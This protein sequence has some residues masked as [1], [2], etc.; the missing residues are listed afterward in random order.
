MRSTIP[1]VLLL[2]GL[3]GSTAVLPARAE[4]APTT[5]ITIAPAPAAAP[6]SATEAKPDDAAREAASAQAEAAD[7]AAFFDAHL[8]AVHTGLTLTPDQEKLWPALDQAIRGVAKMRMSFHDAWVARRQAWEEGHRAG[9]ENPVA[10]L[11]AISDRMLERGKVLGALADAAAP[12]YASLSEDQKRRLPVLLMDAP[13]RGPIGRL[14]AAL[15]GDHDRREGFGRDRHADFDHSD[16]DRRDFHTHGFDHEGD[17]RP[18]FG[19]DGS[20]DDEADHGGFH[21]HGWDHDA[22]DRG[23]EHGDRRWDEHDGSSYSRGDQ[24][25]GNEGHQRHA[26]QDDRGSDENDSQSE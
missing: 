25:S 26:H 16:F 13:R 14:V 23:D 22:R 24:D 6:A 20:Q 1:A 12:L 2:A 15:G 9:M 21:H 4:T 5:T 19:R 8:A 3:L 18:D 17:D 7:R 10:A 11:K